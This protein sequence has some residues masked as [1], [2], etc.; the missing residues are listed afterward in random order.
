MILDLQVRLDLPKLGS[1]SSTHCRSRGL[2]SRGVPHLHGRVC[3][4]LGHLLAIRIVR[5]SLEI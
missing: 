1:P 4:S 3:V 5:V 2:C